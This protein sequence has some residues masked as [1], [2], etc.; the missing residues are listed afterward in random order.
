[1]SWFKGKAGGGPD[2]FRFFAQYGLVGSPV[3]GTRVL[4]ASG[5]GARFKRLVTVVAWNSLATGSVADRTPA[6]ERREIAFNL[7]LFEKH[8]QAVLDM[9]D[10][11]GLDFAGNGDPRQMDCV[12]EA[13][14]ATAYLLAHEGRLRFHAVHEPIAKWGLF[15]ANHYGAVIKDM[16]TSDKWV[17]DGG[18]RPGG[19]QPTI[20]KEHLWYE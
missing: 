4:V 9:A 2:P 16:T 1:M 19:G 14:N 15:K 17:I 5:Y 20:T 6:H 13:W 18:V 12:D 8:F 3:V 7:G 10:R 11:A